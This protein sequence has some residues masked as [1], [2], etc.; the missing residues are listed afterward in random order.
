[1]SRLVTPL[2][3]SPSRRAVLTLIAA[4]CLLASLMIASGN[5]AI[6]LMG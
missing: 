2:S 5:L 1:M 6:Y 4:L 3:S